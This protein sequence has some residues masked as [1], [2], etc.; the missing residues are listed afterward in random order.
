MPDYVLD[1]NSTDIN[2]AINRAHD[3]NNSPQSG[4][5]DKFVTSDGIYQAVNSIGPAN[6]ADDSLVESTETWES[7]NGKLATTAAII[8][9]YQ[10]NGLGLE[11][12]ILGQLTGSQAGTDRAIFNNF[13]T[14][15]GDGGL[16][17]T[18][19]VF[20]FN[21]TGTYMIEAEVYFAVNDHDD[22]AQARVH[23]RPAAEAFND[24]DS[25]ERIRAI[26]SSGNQSGSMRHSYSNNIIFY[27]TS[28]DHFKFTISD[29]GEDGADKFAVYM[30]KSKRFSDSVLTIPSQIY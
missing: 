2:A 24:T 21:K 4:V 29:E 3:P 11:N 8:K 26:I 17:E 27:A 1:Q 22:R 20:T 28:N 13:D 25:E 23:L 12:H 30:V 10:D 7:S 16:V 15:Y 18:N 6:F 9:S 5:T 19:G 14:M